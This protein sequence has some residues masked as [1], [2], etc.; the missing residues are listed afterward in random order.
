LHVDANNSESLYEYFAHRSGGVESHFFVKTNGVLEQYRDTDFQAD[1]NLKANDFAISVETQGFGPGE[2]TEAQLDTIKRLMR[3]AHE[4]H[5]IPFQKVQVWNGTGW[6]YHVQFGAP[7]PWT[8]VAKSCPGFDRIVQFNTILV[9]WMDA[10][11]QQPR[12]PTLNITQALQA[13]DLQDR[14]EALR[15]IAKFGSD[16]A[17]AVAKA[18]LAALKAVEEARQAA[19][20][21]RV[22]LKALEVK[23]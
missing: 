8:P 20:A 10:G 3:W 9:P 22:D 18:W 23:V 21:A 4:V 12:Q 17:S 5:D 14:K 16:D 6:G 2:W 1:A 19:Q 15:K 13:K 7:G 11:G